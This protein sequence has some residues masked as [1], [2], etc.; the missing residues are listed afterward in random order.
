VPEVLEVQVLVV[1]LQMVQF[2]LFQQSHLLVAA[3]EVH[4]VVN[5]EA[6]VEVTEQTQQA[7]KALVMVIHHL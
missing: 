2:Q 6:P 7:V 5:M 1:V 4:Q 3:R